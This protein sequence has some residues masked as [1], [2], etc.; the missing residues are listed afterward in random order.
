MIEGLIIAP[1][2][3]PGDVRTNTN[4]SQHL[5]MLLSIVTLRHIAEWRYSSTILNLGTRW[6]W[7][8]IFTPCHFT[9]GDTLQGTHWIRDWVNPRAGLNTMEKNLLPL[10]GI[11]PGRPALYTEWTI[12]DPKNGVEVITLSCDL[13]NQLPNFVFWKKMGLCKIFRISVRNRTT[14]DS[15]C[16]FQLRFELG[17]APVQGRVTIIPSCI[18]LIR[19]HCP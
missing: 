18:S 5:I 14:S 4:L 15:P 12:K 11:D 8:F 3:G 6:K 7:M 10:L 1:P 9:P 2:K 13:M 19:P 17:T 16:V